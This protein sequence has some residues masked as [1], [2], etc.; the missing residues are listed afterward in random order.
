PTPGAQ[1]GSQKVAGWDRQFVKK[2]WERVDRGE[3]YDFPTGPMAQERLRDILP[4][5]PVDFFTN[6]RSHP[7][8][9]CEPPCAPGVGGAIVHSEKIPH[10]H[11]SWSLALLT[12]KDDAQGA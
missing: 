10:K 12:G 9:F 2:L 5:L 8:T 7:A 4:A 6:W 11:L 1:G 3:R